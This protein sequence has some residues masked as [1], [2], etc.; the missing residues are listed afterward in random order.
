MFKKSLAVFFLFTN[1]AFA[2][3]VWNS[4][5]G[6]KR[7]NRSQFKND[8]Y[9]LVN[10]FQP[11]INPV[12]CSAA[13]SVMVLN[14]LNYGKIESQKNSEITNPENGQVIAYPLYL[15]TSFFNEKTD[16]I[17][18]LS[19][20]QFKEKNAKGNY[21]AGLQIGDLQKILTKVYGAKAKLFYVQNTDEKSVKNFRELAKKTFTDKDNFIIANIDRKA[22][23]QKGSGHFMP[24]VAYDEESDSI[25]ALDP[26]VHK[27][28]WFWVDVAQ[29]YLAMNTK[30]N[31]A[32]RGYLVVSK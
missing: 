7:L 28:H 13:S 16:A 22:L 15:Q 18:K 20:I 11:Q 6:L 12:L 1:F 5:E 25:L 30:D 27:M 9:Q 24:L 23:N 8:F 31:D 29:L 3:E 17:K 21:D 19:V 26:A 2:T 32:Y 4:D 10:F 14:A